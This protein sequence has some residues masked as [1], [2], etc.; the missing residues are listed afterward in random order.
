MN[1][2]LQR[3]QN[4]FTNSIFRK[5]EFVDAEIIN[6]LSGN[7]I[8]S[9]K[10]KLVGKGK[11]FITLEQNCHIEIV[12]EY[13]GEIKGTNNNLVKISGVFTGTINTRIL[14]IS[15]TGVLRGKII[16]KAIK[17]EHGA[18]LDLETNI[19]DKIN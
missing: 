6:N 19:T 14:K 12:G 5:V 7:R 2:L 13:Q 3:I 15:E 10:V 17:I 16:V 11:V 9:N 18:R 1:K 8:I 4:Y